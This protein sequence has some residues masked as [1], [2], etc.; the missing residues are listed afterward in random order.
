MKIETKILKELAKIAPSPKDGRPNLECVRLDG[1]DG[2]ARLWATDGHC[3]VVYQLDAPAPEVATS[4]QIAHIKKLGAKD[5]VYLEGNTL[6]DSRGQLPLAD[7]QSAPEIDNV[8]PEHNDGTTTATI[9]FKPRLMQRVMAC[10][11]KIE[12]GIAAIFNLGTDAMAPVTA[13]AGR[14]KAVIMPYRIK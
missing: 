3:L 6:Q 1:K 5:I 2:K 13:E 14:A 7:D 8:I 12:P 9:G 10:L 11:E 4:Y